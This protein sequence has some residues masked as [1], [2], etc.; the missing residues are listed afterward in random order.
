M[1]AAGGRELA[2]W[3]AE[4]FPQRLLGLA[5]LPAIPAHRGLLIP[6]C[7]AV[8][9]WGMRFAID[10]AF[11]T[12]PPRVGSEV[13]ELWEAVEPRRWARAPGR[14]AR[15]TAALEAPAGALRGL[16]TGTVTFRACPQGT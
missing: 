4:S 8:H 5:G 7:A 11:L 16:D 12:W 1:A 6:R 9:T 2:A 14:R 13:V 15:H 10:V 3:V